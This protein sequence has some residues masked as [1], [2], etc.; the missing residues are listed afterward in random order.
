M[1]TSEQDAALERLREALA[2]VLSCLP[3][4]SPGRH[5]L[6]E[7][8]EEFERGDLPSSRRARRAHGARRGQPRLREGARLAKGIHSE[9]TGPCAPWVAHPSVGKRKER[10][11]RASEKP[12]AAA[13]WFQSRR[14]VAMLACACSTVVVAGRSRTAPI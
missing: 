8:L 12:K 1:N 9:V 6:G 3:L 13:N 14:F 5:E 2:N 11:K 10:S 4:E 7:W